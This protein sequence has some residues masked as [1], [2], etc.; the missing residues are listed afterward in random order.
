VLS[1]P[2]Q[3]G[4]LTNQYR[5]PNDGL[6]IENAIILQNSLRWPLMVD[7]QMQANTWLKNM[8]SNMV[9]MKAS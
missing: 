9:V 6:S 3:V 4:T 5:L 8:E 1:D 2:V 7:P